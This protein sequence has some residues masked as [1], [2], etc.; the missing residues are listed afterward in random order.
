MDDAQLDVGLRVNAVYRIREAFQT[1]HSG[2]QDI[3][4]ATVFQLRQHIQPELC[5]FIFGQPH[6]G[7]FLLA[8]G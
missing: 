7:E 8:S 4:K 1:V 2:N 3:L 6:A 5:A